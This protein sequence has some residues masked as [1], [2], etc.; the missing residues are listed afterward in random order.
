MTLRE[1]RIGDGRLL[2]PVFLLI[3]TTIYL[4]DAIQLAP[5]I[6]N[7]VLTASFFPVVISTIMYVALLCVLWDIARVPKEAAGSSTE[8][9]DQPL[10]P[11]WITL[12]TGA[13]IFTFST[14]GYFLPTFFYVFLMTILF[15]KG[16]EGL[17]FKAAAS[18]IITA[19]GFLLFGLAFQV[20]LPTLWSM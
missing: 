14:I 4:I 17:L 18:L 19:A 2:V 12:L 6:Q 16:L 5:P 20:R 1:T 9:V 3:A 15:G 13:Y 10:G 8:K 7:G 11:L